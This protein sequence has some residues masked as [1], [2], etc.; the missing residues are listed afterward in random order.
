MKKKNNFT[1]LQNENFEFIKAY[2]K[3][4]TVLKSFIDSVNFVQKQNEGIKDAYVLECVLEC[5][6]FYSVIIYDADTE[7]GSFDVEFMFEN[8]EHRFAIYDIFNL[9]DIQDFKTYLHT[10]CID[11]GTIKSAIDNLLDLIEKYSYDLKKAGEEDNLKALCKMYEDDKSDNQSMKLSYLIRRAKLEDKL[12]STKSDKARERLIR[13][14]EKDEVKGVINTYDRRYLKYLKAG[15]E[16]EDDEDVSQEYEKTYRKCSLKIY[17]LMA[18]GSVALV[19]LICVLT[20]LIAFDGGFVP[21]NKFNFITLIISIPFLWMF[22]CKT[23]GEKLI[24]K[25]TPENLHSY[26]KI[27]FDENYKISSKKWKKVDKFFTRVGSVFV[28]ILFISM[29]LSNIGFCDDFIKVYYAPGITDTVE[30]ENATVYKIENYYDDVEEQYAPYENVC[31]AVGYE[32]EYYFIGSVKSAKT[33]DKLNSIFNEHNLKIELIENAD[34]L[35]EIYYIN[36]E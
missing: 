2:V 13:Q 31:Y 20:Y 23:I 10:D 25:I 18:L 9:F 3:K 29:A 34:K 32:N 28:F 7:S 22:L 11:K 21:V 12:Q 36:G 24:L 26:I 35:D 1:N 30:Y 4:Q 6:Y 19:L 14:L 17:A 15:Y 5:R 8:C 27:K 16:I 33:L